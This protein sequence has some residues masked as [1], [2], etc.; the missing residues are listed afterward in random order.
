[1]NGNFTDAEADKI[2]AYLGQGTY[3]RWDPLDAEAKMLLNKR[4]KADKVLWDFDKRFSVLSPYGTD[5]V[6]KIRNDLIEGWDLIIAGKFP[7]PEQYHKLLD[8]YE[9]AIDAADLLLHVAETIPIIGLVQG[10]VSVKSLGLAASAGKL[11]SKL[12]KLDSLLA[13]AMT[14][15]IEAHIQQALGLVSAAISL[16]V[17][18]LGLLAKG[19]LT[20]ADFLLDDVL[21][22]EK[23]DKDSSRGDAAKGMGY[24]M[25]IMEDIAPMGAARKSFA[26]KAGKNLTVVGVYFD[27]KEVAQANAFL[28]TVK[29]AMAT[30]QTE[31]KSLTEK[32]KVALSELSRVQKHMESVMRPLQKA[33]DNKRYQCD[34]LIHDMGYPIIKPYKWI[35]V[36][37]LTRIPLAR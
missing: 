18:G 11:R 27:Y 16:M 15:K 2:N 6:E 17:P 4:K 35:V 32:L 20:A 28:E 13:Q 24:V 31:L 25:D 12:L 21:G 3:E 19:S 7:A 36:S 30:C 5:R 26:G 37:D 33:A 29:S 10:A 9:V 34:Q 22:P 14:L 1:M 23:S 8:L